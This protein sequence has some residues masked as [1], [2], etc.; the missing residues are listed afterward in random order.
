MEHSSSHLLQHGDDFH[1]LSLIVL[2]GSEAAF[3]DGTGIGAYS[4]FNLLYLRAY[5]SRKGGSSFKKMCDD[6]MGHKYN[7]CPTPNKQ[8]WGT[9]GVAAV[10]FFKDEDDVSTSLRFSGY[11]AVPMVWDY[12]TNATKNQ[13]RDRCKEISDMQRDPRILVGVAYEAEIYMKFYE[14]RLVWNKA[15]SSNGYDY[16]F[17]GGD[18]PKEIDRRL[19]WLKKVSLFLLCPHS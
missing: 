17:K 18:F 12:A 11:T 6:Y 19:A 16:M 7:L 5:V 14:R 9:T 2:A 10:R 8:R 4:H 3:G 1:K 13:V 15:R